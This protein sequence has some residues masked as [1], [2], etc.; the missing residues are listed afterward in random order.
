VSEALI[1]M[2]CKQKK[3]I[4]IFN[5]KTRGFIRKI[6]FAENVYVEELKLFSLEQGKQTFI[7]Y[8]LAG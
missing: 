3:A 1:V 5:R 2:A 7:F 6:Q 4:S 8:S